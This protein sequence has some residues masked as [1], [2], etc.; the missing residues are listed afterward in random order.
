MTRH[1]RLFAIA[2]LFGLGAYAVAWI[3]VLASRRTG[4]LAWL[5]G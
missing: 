5:A 4:L 3:L 2:T 1:L